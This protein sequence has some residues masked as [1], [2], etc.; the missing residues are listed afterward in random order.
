MK[1]IFFKF[2]LAPAMLAA[3]FVANAA[4]TTTTLKVPFNFTVA[5]HVCPAGK[6]T[7]ESS[8]AGSFV[9]LTDRE[10]AK[11]FSF[12]VEPGEPAP[13]DTRVVLNFDQNGEAHTLRTIQYGHLITSV[14][15]TP[16]SERTTPSPVAGQ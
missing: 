10:S 6:Y 16:A 3:A 9:T 7:V 13:T 5:G 1:S 4:T 11:T 15:P 14:L 8:N 2:A 12:A